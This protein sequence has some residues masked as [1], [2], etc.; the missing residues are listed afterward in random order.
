MPMDAPHILLAQSLALAGLV[1]A[2][3]EYCEII[4]RRA[5]ARRVDVDRRAAEASGLVG[6]VRVFLTDR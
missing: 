5:R 3:I 2:T 6:M 4:Q 1:G